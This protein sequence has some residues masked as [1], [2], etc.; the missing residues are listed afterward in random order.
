MPVSRQ[1][2]ENSEE[3]GLFEAK[4]FR[5]TE[6]RARRARDL[7]VEGR[8]DTDDYGRR[9]WRDDG[10]K[11][12]VLTVNGRSGS[13]V[14]SFVAK[15]SGR[16]VRQ[17]LGEIEVVNLN[18]ARE[19]VGRLRHDRTTAGVLVHRS[20]KDQGDQGSAK[21]GVVVVKM[22]D[23]HRAGRWLPGRRRRQGPPT[24]K[25]M[26]F[27]TELHRA[28]TK[29]YD[30]MTLAEFAESLPEIYAKLQKRA[31]VQ[32]NRAVQ[33]WRNVFYYA[34]DAGFWAGV[35]PAAD[36]AGT[37]RLTKTPEVPRQRILSDPEWKR[38]DKAMA[39]DDPLWRD[40]F[41]MS[42]RTLQRMGACCRAR[43]DGITLT[44][45][46]A[47]WRIPSS[48]MKGRAGGHVVPLA[49]M[50]DLL[51]VLRARRKLV[52]KDCPWVFPAFESDGPVTSYKTAWKRIL[53]RAKLDSKDRNRRPRPHDLRR[54]GGSRMVSAGVPLNIVTKALGDSQ[55]S[56]GMV[57]KTYAV[58][59]DEALADAYAVTSKKSRR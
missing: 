45:K 36:T 37:S 59:V 20:A 39:A 50:P 14:W 34:V 7:V 53:E 43:W 17:A 38:L 3:L 11:G 6:A 8:L 51:A 55:S 1:K 13:A 41:T 23:D 56:V 44:G 57:A 58:V 15:V 32:A 19:A 46:D 21:V 30:N 27:Y 47:A 28:T 5:F 10:M 54:T 9:S 42:I 40:L 25:T 18:D 24:E 16:T 29:E 52:P 2:H 12:L 22:L 33:L 31:P 49:G 35:N 48:D 26:N 4:S